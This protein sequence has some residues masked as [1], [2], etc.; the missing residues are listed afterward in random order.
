MEVVVW[1]RSQKIYNV[2]EE[3]ASEEWLWFDVGVK[4]Y[5]TKE[6]VPY[7]PIGCGLM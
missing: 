2:M 3:G 1:C 4:R 7:S 5:T 6:D